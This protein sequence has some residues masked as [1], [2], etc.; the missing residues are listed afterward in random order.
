MLGTWLAVSR[1]QWPDRQVA[2]L[3]HMQKVPTCSAGWQGCQGRRP[4]TLA[5]LTS[6]PCRSVD[7][8]PLLT[9]VAHAWFDKRTT[10][11]VV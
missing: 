7:M 8:T 1:K 4:T 9:M 11:C 10:I 2:H 5:T 6:A 3:R